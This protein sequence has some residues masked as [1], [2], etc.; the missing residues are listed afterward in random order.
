MNAIWNQKSPAPSRF[1]TWNAASGAVQTCSTFQEKLKTLQPPRL[2]LTAVSSACRMPDW[3]Y[4]APEGTL[5]P[6]DVPQG[7][8][9]QHT[10]PDQGRPVD[11]FEIMLLLCIQMQSLQSVA[12]WCCAWKQDQLNPAL[13]FHFS[14]PTRQLSMAKIPSCN[15]LDSLDPPPSPSYNVWC[16]HHLQET[17]FLKLTNRNRHTKISIISIIS[18]FEW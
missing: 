11:L 5:P 12:S 13:R 7:P 4:E 16:E 10:R 3:V 8:A 17:A 1:R 14:F 15:F 9:F 18:N 6:M 2:D